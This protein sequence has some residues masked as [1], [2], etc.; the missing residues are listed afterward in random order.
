MATPWTFEEDFL[1]CEFYFEHLEKDWKPNIDELMDRLKKS[2]FGQRERGSAIMRVQNYDFLHTGARGLSKAAKQT[3]RVYEAFRK[4][5]TNAAIHGNFNQR[6]NATLENDISNIPASIFTQPK[7][8]SF[9]L[10][11]LTV[12]AI[13]IYNSM[14]GAGTQATFW[15]VL[16]KF[17]DQRGF[18]KDSDVYKP[19]QVQ[20]DVFSNIRNG[21]G[22]SKK[23]VFQL[24]F[25]LKLNADEAVVLLASAGYA[26][27]AKK[28]PDE[29]VLKYLKRKD[30]DIFSANIEL[31][32]LKVPR[33]F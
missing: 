29:I 28:N 15:E 6:I 13:N 16:C 7:S 32:D 4:L 2:G 10:S 25:G 14:F 24:C 8:S 33:L 3:Q 22:V 18:K 9:N 1:V 23:T 17:I 26:F 20:R 5:W 12:D 21:K 11:Y 31:Y 30:H 27:E 19:C